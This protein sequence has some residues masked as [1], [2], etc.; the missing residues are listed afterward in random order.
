MALNYVNTSIPPN[1][2]SSTIPW[3][4]GR[5][6]VAFICF[7]DAVV[8]VVC[9]DLC[10]LC[11]TM[12]EGLLYAVSTGILLHQRRLDAAGSGLCV[13]SQSNPSAMCVPVG[14]APG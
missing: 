5:R 3:R 6:D 14:T 13:S 10:C 9:G 4:D 7:L 2:T 1:R 12:A 11:Q 8:A